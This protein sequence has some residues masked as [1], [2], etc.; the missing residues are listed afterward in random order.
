MTR[1][2][3]MGIERDPSN[4]LRKLRYHVDTLIGVIITHVQCTQTNTIRQTDSSLVPMVRLLPIENDLIP[5]VLLVN[6][7]LVKGT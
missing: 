7:H 6:M 2:L 1:Y 5:V 4:P 3:L